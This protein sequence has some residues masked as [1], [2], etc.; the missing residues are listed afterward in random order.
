MVTAD[1]PT[2]VAESLFDSVVVEDFQS[3][4]RL[5]DPTGTDESDGFE[6]L[7]Q[8]DDPVDQLATSETGPWRRGRRLA[9]RTRRKCEMLDPTVVGVAD[10]VLAWT[11]VSG[12]L[13]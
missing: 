11:A 9:R 4:G 8:V 12:H 5:P 13:V 3:D 10:L 2:F 7:G 1:E 6:V